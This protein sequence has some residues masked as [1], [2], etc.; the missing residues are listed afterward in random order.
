MHSTQVSPWSPPLTAAEGTHDA[1][2]AWYGESPHPAHGS[3]RLL[4]LL[5]PVWQ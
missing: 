2:A 4:R 5:F 1:F 3:H